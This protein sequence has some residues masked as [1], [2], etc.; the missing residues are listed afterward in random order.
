MPRR[1]SSPRFVGRSEELAVLDAMLERAAAGAG[2]AVLVE[3]E[4]GIGKSR[5]M[6][7]LEAQADAAGVR[8]LIAECLQLAEGELAFAPIVS[9]LRSVVEHAELLDS[10]D[11]TLRSAIVALWPAAGPSDARPGEREQLFEGVYR[12]LARLAARTPVLLIVED[13]H[14]IDPSSRD[15]LSFLVHNARRDPIVLVATYRSDELH[16]AHPLRPFLAELE[17][18]GRA[19]RLELGGLSHAEVAEQIAAITGRLPDPA[20]VAEIFA[21]SEGNPFY[22]EELLGAEGAGGGASGLPSS[23][24]EALLLRLLRFSAYAREVLSAAAVIGR[25]IDHRLLAGVVRGTEDE[26]LAV[27]RDAAEHHIL[28]TARSGLA[29]RFRH[30]LLREA[31]YEDTLPGERL[32][33]HRAIAQALTQRPE[34]AGEDLT[35]SAELA[36]HWYAARELPAALA[37]S[38]Q[39]ATEAAAVHAHPEALRHLQRALKLWDEVPTASE[40]TGTDQFG[41]L[42]RTADMS[43]HAG[44]D[45]LSVD[46]TLRARTLVD[47]RVEPVRAGVAET[48]IGRALFNAGRADDALEHLAEAVRL[49]PERPPSVERARALAA[50]GRLLMLNGLFSKALGVL[51]EALVLAG[52]LEARGVE[53]SA[54]NTICLVYN[55]LGEWHRAI[56]AGRRGLELAV[57]LEDGAEMLRGYINGSQVIDNAGHIEEALALGLEGVATGDRLGLDRAAGDQLRSQAAWRLIRLGRFA[58]AEDVI[59]PAL[60]GATVAFNIGG[61]RSTAGYLAG[62]RGEFDHADELLEPAWELMQHS[63][64]FQQIGLAMGWRIALRLWRDENEGARQLAREGVERVS[65]AEG[66][67][68]YTG[69]LY[70]LAARAEAEMAELARARG[71]PSQADA[72]AAATVVESLCAAIG[73]SPGDG[74]PPAALAYELLA[75]AELARAHGDRDAR[76]WRAAAEPFAA[77]G[78]GYHSAYALMRAAEASALAG[79]PAREVADPLRAAHAAALELGVV[80]FRAEVEELARRTGIGLDLRHRSGSGLSEELGLTERE[81]EVLRLVAEGR[82]NR[83]IA[84]E[85]FITSKTASAHVSHI[86][87]KLGVAN[88][89]AAAAAAHRLGLTRSPVA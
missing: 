89:A 50:Y 72:G 25:S 38:V 35:A 43:E 56:L 3:G 24:R 16:R 36:H 75:R 14:W 2:G 60:E 5:L 37:A 68:V 87:M 20:S 73:N 1:V 58:E 47:D 9:A 49:V 48:E 61:T 13:V 34:L 6:A 76:P 29:Y 57:E 83:E 66:Q 18:S 55:Q 70:W 88:R 65:A 51:E 31:I 71:Q 81:I 23:L 33:L 22:V 21:R 15:L 46:L 53:A 77:L 52:R 59:R 67:L 10:L 62:V 78:H 39:A 8:V 45:K 12:M 80:P 40:L 26:L 74:A 42:L 41:L 64:S 28:V 86:L 84:R 32:R 17:R 82:S 54:L 7:R 79:S 85:L 27:L 30:A 4:A 69:E 19:E 44:N 11:P 63:G